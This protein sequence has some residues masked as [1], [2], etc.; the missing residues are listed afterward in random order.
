MKLKHRAMSIVL[1][2][3]LVVTLMPAVAFAGRAEKGQTEK[4]KKVVTK[5]NIEVNKGLQKN[6]KDTD[7]YDYVFLD[8]SWVEDVLADSSLTLNVPL[9][10]GVSGLIYKWYVDKTPDEE[11]YTWEL[12]PGATGKSLNVN[13]T[14][15][16]KAVV[17]GTISGKYIEESCIFELY[18]IWELY[19]ND[20][21]VCIDYEDSYLHAYVTSYDEN[22]HDLQ[23]RIRKGGITIVDWSDMD[24]VDGD[25]DYYVAYYAEYFDFGNYTFEVRELSTGKSKSCNFA[26]G[27]YYPVSINGLRFELNSFD[28][29][30][31][32]GLWG[33][34]DW[35]LR[36]TVTVP[37]Q[38]TLSNRKT[39]TVTIVDTELPDTVTGIVVPSTVTEID[40]IGYDDYGNKI[41]GFTIIGKTGSEAQRY[42]ND[43]GF[44]FRDP[45]AEAAAA[46]VAEAQRQA[47]LTAASNINKAT[48]TA[49]DIMNAASLG[50]TVVTLGPKVKKIKGNA[51][52]GT[53]ITTV[54]VQTKKLKAKSVKGSMKGSSVTSINVSFGKAKLNKKFKKAYKKI[55]TKKNAGKKVK[56]S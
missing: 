36:G 20:E 44:A 8:D 30:D 14:G 54:V 46:Q 21:E 15:Y 50:A 55:F 27:S 18:D 28:E 10:D 41:P 11:D 38:V 47:A 45:D 49:G 2:L 48:V 19:L 32:A 53:G 5:N 7:Y 43:C 51:F 34:Y 31:Q 25:G 13:R 26:V 24:D 16:Y 4:S 40:S 42:A 1:V 33:V 3:V 17:G 12:I 56:V 29:K 6:T 9:K 35:N 39:Y 52:K 37:S 23:Y 22:D